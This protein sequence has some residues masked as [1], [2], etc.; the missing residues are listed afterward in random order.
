MMV[1]T[2]A[3]GLFVLYESFQW[4][5]AGLSSRLSKEINTG[6]EYW[7]IMVQKFRESLQ[8]GI[9][10]NFRDSCSRIQFLNFVNKID[11]E[12]NY[13]I[14]EKYCAT[15]IWSYTVVATQNEQWTK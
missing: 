1:S 10:V 8:I 7:I 9:E 5:T 6:L 11:P 2:L 14:H 4:L 12:V 15:K 13:K 3:L